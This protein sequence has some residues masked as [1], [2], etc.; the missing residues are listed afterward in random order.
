[1][2]QPESR[3]PLK[4]SSRSEESY[5]SFLSALAIPDAFAVRGF[6]HPPGAPLHTMLGDHPRLHA[7]ERHARQLLGAPRGTLT[8][9]QVTLMRLSDMA[10]RQ[11]ATCSCRLSGRSAA[12]RTWKRRRGCLKQAQHSSSSAARR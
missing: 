1:M 6:R 5:D 9:Y 8:V 10:R 12:K 7:R 11:M 4:H 2:A 3:P